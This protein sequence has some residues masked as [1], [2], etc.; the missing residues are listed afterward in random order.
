MPDR[1]REEEEENEK[2]DNG[3]QVPCTA[4]P[5]EERDWNDS[6]SLWGAMDLVSA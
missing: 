3:K 5:L 4:V 6:M 2:G 1:R